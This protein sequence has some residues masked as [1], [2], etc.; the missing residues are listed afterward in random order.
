MKKLLATLTCLLISLT[1]LIPNTIG[2]IADDDNQNKHQ[3][4][5]REELFAP[6]SN[7]FLSRTASVYKDVNGKDVTVYGFYREFSEQY[8]PNFSQALLIYQCIKYKEKYPE[9]PTSIT[10]Q[11]FHFSVVFS[12]CVDHTKTNYGEVKNLYDKDYDEDGY[13]RLSY[14]LVEAAKKGVEVCVI[15]QLDA[16]PTLQLEGG[17][18]KEIPDLSF[19]DYFNSHLTDDAYISGKKVSDFMTFGNCQ[20]KCYGDKS[21][22]D[23]MHNKT[24]SVSNYIDNDGNEHGPAIWAGSI[25]IDGIDY[26]GRNGLDTIQTAVIVAEHEQLRN[27]L[28][29]YTKLMTGYCN[30]EDVVPFRVEMIKRNTEQIKLI[31]EGKQN[32]IPEGERVVYLGTEDD[33]IF[34]LY[35]TP[36]GGSF[37]TW[38]TTYNPYCKYLSQMLEASK[39][40][41][42]L[43][44]VWN[45]VKFYETFDLGITILDV[46]NKSFENNNNLDS[47]I[48]LVML[49]LDASSF[50]NL[51]VGENIG[52]KNINSPFYRYHSKDLQM[53]YVYDGER[54]FIS[55][56]NSLNMHE[57]SSYHQTNTA[58]VIKERERIGN[59]FYVEFAT[60]SSPGLNILTH[61]I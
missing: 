61:R 6:L 19:V 21:A 56:L 41:G 33:D 53:S 31:M 11:S 2:A 54:R 17:V 12:A 52:Y 4:T 29:N 9:K 25:N 18:E 42:H 32:E 60:L 38:D 28:Y 30:Q 49:F 37:S 26:L 59:N 51:V 55:I 48:R 44:L 20:W 50:D 34:E 22:A 10:V 35:F 57:G 13:Y 58:L 39:G 47:L 36:F 46:I 5:T 16:S 23:M 27:T 1:C 45:N 8:N 40:E 15:G 7:D 3:A 14:L 24:C 43:E